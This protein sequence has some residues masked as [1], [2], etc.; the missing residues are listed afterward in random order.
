MSRPKTESLT[1]AVADGTKMGAFLAR[2][3]AAGPRPGIIV[4]QEAFGVNAQI[5]GAAERFARAGYVALAPELFHRTAPGFDGP[6]GDFEAARPHYSALTVEG[7]L[8]DLTAAYDWLKRPDAGAAADVSAIGFCLGGRAAF[9]ANS[10]LKLKAAVSFYGAGIAPALLDRAPRQSGPI[11]LFWGG[12][13]KHIP[14][15]QIASVTKALGDAGK[16]YASVV[17]SSA[18]HGFFNDARASYHAA[19][20]ASAWALTLQFLET[21]N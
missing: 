21:P 15:E 3:D 6:Y 5:R 12:L 9:L 11:L 16:P 4:I 10:A 2:P 13:D 19:S 20:A 7:Q 14:P 8:A 17:F 1:L 18:D